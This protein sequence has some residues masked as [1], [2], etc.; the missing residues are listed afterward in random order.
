MFWIEL[1]L[2]IQMAIWFASRLELNLSVG[3][4]NALSVFLALGMKSVLLFIYITLG[5]AR[6]IAI[7][8]ILTFIVFLL[9]FN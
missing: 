2:V 9:Y 6:F 5:L 8:A 1:Y 4:R 7:P 3:E